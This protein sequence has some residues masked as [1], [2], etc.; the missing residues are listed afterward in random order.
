MTFAI[1]PLLVAHTVVAPV[2]IVVTDDDGKGLAGLEVEV[3][4]YR[5]EFRRSKPTNR[6]GK[7]TL[8]PSGFKPLDTLVVE[9]KGYYPDSHFWQDVV[10]EDPIRFILVPERNPK[11]CRVTVQRVVRELQADG[12][13]VC[14]TVRE[15]AYRPC[16]QS[17]AVYQ[18]P[19]RPPPLGYKYQFAYA[20]TRW[21]ATRQMWAHRPYYI[22]VPAC[23][24]QRSV[25]PPCA[26]GQVRTPAW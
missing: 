22:L 6:D 1:V 23:P 3:E 13:V 25:A 12:T 18:L 10:E 17:G 26:C 8:D 21:D 11:L 20:V 15:T 4:R 5:S 16:P 9:R 19:E 24:Q 7:T 14:R 2:N